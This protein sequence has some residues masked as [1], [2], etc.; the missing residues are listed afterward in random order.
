[1][2]PRLRLPQTTQGIALWLGILTLATRFPY[3]FEA[4]IDWDES[5]FILLGQSVL[6]GHLPYTDL[7]DVKP[8]LLWVFFALSIAIFGKTIASVRLAGAICVFLT[9]LMTYSLGRKVWH[10]K[11]GTIAASLF[12]IVTGLSPSGQAV[13]SEHVAIVPLMATLTLA[14]VGNNRLRDYFLMGGLMAVAIL[15][16]LNLIYAAIAIG[17]II[18]FF[19]PHDRPRQVKLILS[20][21]LAY[22]LGG[23]SIVLLTILPYATIGRIE[24]WWVGAIDTSLS[25]ANAQQSPFAAIG[26]LREQIED[27]FNIARGRISLAL[28]GLALLVWLGGLLEI[29]HLMHYWKKLEM[30]QQRSI[31]LLLATLIGI[32]LS[33]LKGGF[34]YG[35]YWLQ[36]NSILS[37]FA[38]IFSLRL[39]SSSHGRIF[40]YF[41]S[42]LLVTVFFHISL[43]YLRLGL[44]LA[45]DRHLFYG[46]AWDIAEFLERENPYRQPVLLLD[47]HLAYWLTEN[48][49][50]IP[51]AAHPSNLK[52]EYL[53][54]AWLGK[55]ASTVKELRKIFALKPK[56]IIGDEPTSFFPNPAGSEFAHTLDRDYIAIEKIDGVEVYKRCQ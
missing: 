48:P 21:S 7:L 55:D 2:P 50:P 44:E 40:T 8:P 20:R 30:Y 13:M 14:V 19:P 23:L 4:T 1:M 34:F 54:K 10:N 42:I 16:R 24:L 46:R 18:V 36:F 47:S 6:D 5:T 12:I 28:I 35:H 3:F 17:L 31:A 25:Y 56:F 49:P 51:T 53:L 27:L 29:F 9:A 11:I 52:K 32:E 33:I 43:K 26:V 38:A 41:V 22:I 45:Y 39:L 37:L 15:V